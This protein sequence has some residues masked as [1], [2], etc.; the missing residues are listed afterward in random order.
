LNADLNHVVLIDVL[1]QRSVDDVAKNSQ[2][3]ACPDSAVWST[4]TV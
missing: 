4:L 2:R 1:G 3:Q